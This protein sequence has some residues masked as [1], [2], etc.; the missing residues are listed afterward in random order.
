[1]NQKEERKMKRHAKGSHLKQKTEVRPNNPNSKAFRVR[2]SEGTISRPKGLMSF[3]NTITHS[4]IMIRKQDLYK[5]FMARKAN[6]GIKML[7]DLEEKVFDQLL[8][9]S[10]EGFLK[11]NKEVFSR[12]FWFVAF[13]FCYSPR[14]A[15]LADKYA[16]LFIEHL[17]SSDF[18]AEFQGAILEY[19]SGRAKQPPVLNS[20]QG[21]MDRVNWFCSASELSSNFSTNAN[22][23]EINNSSLKCGIIVNGEEGAGKRTAIT[24]FVNTFE[25][26]AE[27]IDLSTFSALKDISNRFSSAVLMNDVKIS[28]KCGSENL[29]RLGSESAHSLLNFNEDLGRKRN[30][31][32]FSSPAQPFS[33]R[34][35][36]SGQRVFQ[37]DKVHPRILSNQIGNIH[38][39]RTIKK[40]EKVLDRSASSSSL[41]QIEVPQNQFLGKRKIDC[42]S[43]HSKRQSDKID[44]YFPRADHKK[45]QQSCPEISTSQMTSGFTKP[46]GFKNVL[47]EIILESD[48]ITLPRELRSREPMIYEKSMQSEFSYFPHAF[49]QN[50][51][52]FAEKRDVYWTKRKIYICHNLDF[53]YHTQFKNDSGRFAKKFKE[54]WMFLKSS[55][56]PFVFVHSDKLNDFYGKHLSNFCVVNKQSPAFEEVSLLVYLV[57]LFESN[58][59][60]LKNVFLTYTEGQIANSA[61]DLSRII[62][63]NLSVFEHFLNAKLSFTAPSIEQTCYINHLCKS[64]CTKIFSLLSLN[65]ELV[66][67]DI[68]P[69]KRESTYRTEKKTGY[70][71]EKDGVKFYFE[72]L[73]QQKPVISS[74]NKKQRTGFD[75]ELDN[76]FD[77]SNQ[78]MLKSVYRTFVSINPELEL[79]E[80][81]ST[82]VLQRAQ[83][84]AG[85]WNKVSS[86]NPFFIGKSKNQSALLDLRSLDLQVQAMMTAD[87]L[88]QL[89][90]IHDLPN[91]TAINSRI[92]DDFKMSSLVNHAIQ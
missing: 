4:S 66:L 46:I 62:E 74:S 21:S 33:D 85:L 51:R 32:E 11:S 60:P 49:D 52:T 44:D 56:Y 48:N 35:L 10:F 75:L 1:M 39:S 16:P 37:E 38:S 64:N 12:L 23:N 6:S 45:V 57:M 27:H 86:A 8:E 9:S 92:K 3:F 65:P 36:W 13:S 87:H 2:P 42:N 77:M 73:Q 41:K 88:Q 91:H 5:T 76:A 68:V 72:T 83:N 71:M 63:T 26:E 31:L 84:L 58:F 67:A 82:K 28:L 54:F 7:A 14:N 29:S 70:S 19:F 78:P 81:F 24:A 25:F 18:A 43:K 89:E 90:T 22:S 53:I 79:D 15:L 55:G 59:R 69:I 40:V 34:L 30:A 20:N 50:S 47:P 17:F 61:D 80:R